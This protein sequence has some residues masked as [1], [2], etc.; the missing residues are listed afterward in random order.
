[1]AASCVD[2]AVRN[3]IVAG[4]ELSFIALL[5]NFCW[6]SPEHPEK[7]YQ[8][9]M[10]SKACYDLSLNFGTPFISG[11][12]SMYNDFTGYNKS[13]K[14]IKISIPPTLLISSIGIIKSY[15]NLLSIVPQTTD[16]YIYIIGRTGDEMGG[17]EFTKVFGHKNNNVP[18]VDRQNAKRNYNNFSKANQDKLITSAI[19][20]GLGGLAI[21]LAKMAIAS[22][23]G[24]KINLKNINTTSGK[25][26]N[27]HVL[28]SESQSRILVTVNQSN[29]KKF[30]SYFKKNQ[31]SLEEKTIKSKKLFFQCQTKKNLR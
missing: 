28:F 13:N 20:I 25:I 3:L 10:A 18:Q 4:C 30:E 23:T 26:N 9:K 27:S 1:M 12:D 15:H 14:K 5:D 8:L 21:S 7:I 16:D 2:T 11:K 31:L 17:S 19:S 6:C 29:K 24:L 22:Q